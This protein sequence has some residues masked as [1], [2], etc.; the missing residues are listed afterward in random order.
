MRTAICGLARQFPNACFFYLVPLEELKLVS[1]PPF[2]FQENYGKMVMANK[3]VLPIYGR[4]AICRNIFWKLLARFWSGLKTRAHCQAIGA[5]ALDGIKI[6]FS[7][8][9]GDLANILARVTPM[10]MC[11]T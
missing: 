6:L 8:F 4:I 3:S 5:W 2:L 7:A 10:A 11:R 9:R 1:A